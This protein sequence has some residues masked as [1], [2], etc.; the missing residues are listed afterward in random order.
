MCW[1]C[2][3]F[4]KVLKTFGFNSSSF[5]HL[6]SLLNDPIP[7]KVLEYVVSHLE[8]GC[9]FVGGDDLTGALHVL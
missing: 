3:S 5:I 1:G 8:F 4:L 2:L 7:G 9:W 6:Q